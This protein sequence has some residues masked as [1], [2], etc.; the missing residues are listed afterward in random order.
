[1]SDDP[2]EARDLAQTLAQVF[3]EEHLARRSRQD[4]ETR[5]F[6]EKQLDL[7]KSSLAAAEQR[8][9]SFREANRYPVDDD[10]IRVRIEEQVSLGTERRRIVGEIEELEAQLTQLRQRLALSDS[11]LAGRVSVDNAEAGGRKLDWIGSP[12]GAGP[13]GLLNDRMLELETE[14]Q[15]LLEQY[16]PTFPRVREVEREIH[17]LLSE[18]IEETETYVNSRKAQVAQL[19]SALGAIRVM[20]ANIPESQRRYAQLLREVK[21]REEQYAFL[22]EKY[23]EALIR[24]ADQADEVTVVRPAMLNTRPINIHMART[25]G[26]GFA[27]GLMLGLVLAYLFETF[28][29][30]I[31][32]I[33]DVEEYLEV[34]VLGVIPNINVEAV[35]EHMIKS[36]PA[37][38][39]K[40]G[41]D[42]SSRLVTHYA[43]KDPVAES[44]RTLRTTLQFRSITNPVKT[45]TA[46]SASLQEGKTTTLVNLAITLAQGGTRTLLVGCNLRRPTIY[47]IFGLE[48]EPGVV[49]IVMGRLP[50][51]ETVRT[52]T[53]IIMGELGM[54]SAL[55][56]PGMENLHIITSGG[57]PPN[58]SEMI[59]SEKMK[60]FIA[61]SREEYDIVLFDAPPTLPVT[62]AAILANRT[63]ATLLIYRSGRVPRAALKRAKVQL[64]AVGARVLGVVLNDLKAEIA[65]DIG[66]HYYGK[67]YGASGEQEVVSGGG[68]E[69]GV[70]ARL[71]ALFGAGTLRRGSRSPEPPSE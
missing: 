14:K 38:E 55:M 30:S 28:D 34:P 22:S 25:L 61:E 16:R 27:V 48:Q 13:L 56:T 65:G 68:R 23:Q 19:D 2:H 3:T 15:R 40:P 39:G 24:E 43:P 8:L 51:R 4:R 57:I 46:T 67:Y 41:L 7:S 20:F 63:D 45:I 54:D 44:Y 52:V 1:T 9:Q 35:K 53:D 6:I 29:T 33:E 18:L 64:E 12:Q 60:E 69:R 11:M 71:L 62:D 31:G 49:D 21:L 50:W 10:N 37:L 59:A 58:P 26:V 36:N 66:S 5:E 70:L 42:A 17:T 32:T 47:R